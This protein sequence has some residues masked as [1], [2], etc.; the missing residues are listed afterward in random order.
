M[1]SDDPKA[2]LG[3]EEHI[4][5]IKGID[6]DKMTPEQKQALWEQK[7]LERSQD[8]CNNCGGQ[9]KL[10]VQM[11]VPVGASG[12]LSVENGVVLCRAC[13]MAAEVVS[14]APNGS[15][16]RPVNF[17]VSRRLFKKV[18]SLNGFTSTG[19]LVRYLMKKYVLDPDRF[20]DL[21][22]WQDKGTEVKVNVWVENDTYE[23]FKAVVNRRGATVTDA[24]KS[25]IRMYEE[26]AE[27]LL[28]Q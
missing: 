9:H 23:T 8:K 25:L 20:D 13:E 6:P 12:Q 27:T 3:E 24:L 17:W 5:Y 11:I 14:R 22:S 1:A 26:E 7:V 21:E 10:R 19:S 15:A 2:L 4:E 16:E 18:K 28:H